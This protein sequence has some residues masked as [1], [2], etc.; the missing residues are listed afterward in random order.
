MLFFFLSVSYHCAGE[1]NFNSLIQ[2]FT[3][4]VIQILMN[5]GDIKHEVVLC[6]I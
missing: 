3:K 4:D 6:P 5:I 2:A 1:R